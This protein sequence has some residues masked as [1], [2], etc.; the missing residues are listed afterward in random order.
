M[1]GL[2][3]NG[4]RDLIK[5]KYGEQTWDKVLKA[6]KLSESDFIAMQSYPDATTY[7]LVGAALEM[8]DIPAEQ[9]LEAFG[10]HWVL[11]TGPKAY[12][13]LLDMAGDSLPEL[14][15]NLDDLHV[16]V[17]NIMPNMQAPS[18]RCVDITEHRLKLHY[19]SARQGLTPMVLGL[20]HGIGERFQTPCE[21][22]V[23]S[24]EESDKGAHIVFEV[25]W[26]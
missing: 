16:H 26:S 15:G 21:A 3:H 24:S 13:D 22:T 17:A 14:L 25:R 2:V 10:R 6:S 8:L 19:R 7:Q 12:G 9:L 5:L 11:E 1:Y 20:I 4:L 23:L 18:F